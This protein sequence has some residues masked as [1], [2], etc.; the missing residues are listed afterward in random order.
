MKLPA[1]KYDK[2]FSKP[3]IS[4]STTIRSV[5]NDNAIQ[6]GEPVRAY[7]YQ[8]TGQDGSIFTIEM[9]PVNQPEVIKVNVPKNNQD[10]YHVYYGGNLSNVREFDASLVIQLGN[11][12]EEHVI[13]NTSVVHINADNANEDIVFKTVNKPV[14]FQNF[15]YSPPT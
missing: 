6:D 5:S 12:K 7:T 15:Q 14:L 4:L 8:N 1:A 2:Y 10:Q 11:E 9:Y 3:S 13:E